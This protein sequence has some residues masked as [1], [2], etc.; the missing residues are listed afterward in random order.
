MKKLF[1]IRHAKSSWDHPRLRDRDRPLNSRGQNDAPRMAKLF[2]REVGSVDQLISSPAVRAL[3]TCK[4]FSR[5]LSIPEDSILVQESI[6]GAST[7]SLL[8]LINNFNEAWSSVCIFGHN[9]TFTYL[10]EELAN[11]N[12]GNLP[13]CGIVGIEFGV[14]DWAAISFGSGSEFLFEY[15]KK[16]D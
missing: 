15:P 1:I 13:T 4:I 16:L 11:I 8:D 12:I 5:E 14:E 9:P 7:S 6:Y 10:A 2:K 3:T